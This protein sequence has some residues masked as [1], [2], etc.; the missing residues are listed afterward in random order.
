MLVKRKVQSQKKA[1][2]TGS[3]RR[4]G[5]VGRWLVVVGQKMAVGCSLDLTWEKGVT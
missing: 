5:G 2:K 3:S 4:S 1:A